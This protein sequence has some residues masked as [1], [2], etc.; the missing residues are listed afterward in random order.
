MPVF[1]WVWIRYGHSGEG[2]RVYGEAQLFWPVI[3]DICDEQSCCSL[4]LASSS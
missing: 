2:S 1:F 3:I 4:G